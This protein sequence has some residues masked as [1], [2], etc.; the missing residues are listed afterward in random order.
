MH[1]NRPL[2]AVIIDDEPDSRIALRKL[3]ELYAPHVEVLAEGGGV[4]EGLAVVTQARPELLLLDIRIADGTGFDLLNRLRE[5]GVPCKVV[6]V[7]GFDQ[8]AVKAFK[9]LAID[10]L[11][12][13]V[14]PD[15]LELAMGKVADALNYDALQAAAYD[16][17]AP[18]REPESLVIAGLK[19]HKVLRI[20]DIATLQANGN[21]VF[22]NM[23]NG[24]QHLASHTLAH[25][26]QML[27]ETRF[28]R[29]HRS[30]LV[31]RECIA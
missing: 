19:S 11:L 18:G 9:Y 24:E 15:E 8:Y 22:F 30:W 14:D 13:P 26:E 31:N 10:Y 17:L 16:E 12:K 4:E 6:F 25:Y 27:P 21:Y 1:P 23:L 5:N 2:T 28:V 3:L 7:T 29:A 20:A